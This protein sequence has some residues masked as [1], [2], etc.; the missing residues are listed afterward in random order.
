MKMKSATI[1]FALFLGSAL[2][3]LGSAAHADTDCKDTCQEQYDECIHKHTSWGPDPA[4][5][6]QQ[7]ACLA[8]CTRSRDA[9]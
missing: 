1:G 2:L 4:C 7:T 8:M 3:L 6:E 9:N 5:E